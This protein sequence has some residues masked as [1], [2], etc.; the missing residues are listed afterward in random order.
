MPAEQRE[1]LWISIDADLLREIDALAKA[2]N[3]PR[4]DAA[5]VLLRLGVEILQQR[6]G[7]P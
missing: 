1:S 5:R 4:H 2:K 6:R 7:R 3:V